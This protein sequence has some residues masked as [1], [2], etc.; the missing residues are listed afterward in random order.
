MEAFR[1]SIKGRS[2]DTQKANRV[3]KEV[4]A[5]ESEIKELK[6]NSLMLIKNE[7]S[8][9]QQQQLDNI[10]ETNPQY[11]KAFELNLGNSENG[12]KMIIHD[13]PGSPLMEQEKAVYF[14]IG[15]NMKKTLKFEDMNEISH[16][17]IESIS[18]FKGEM[19]IEKYGQQGKDGVVEVKIRESA[20][21]KYFK[22]N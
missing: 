16:G 3:F 19:A 14:L 1:E 7:L 13:K 4:L 17:D 5:L 18:V 11:V 12:T 8:A 10:K 2:A 15:N 6:L 22:K 20:V 9:D 21:S